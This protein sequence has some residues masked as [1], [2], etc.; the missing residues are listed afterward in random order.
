M[1]CAFRA[2]C[3]VRVFMLACFEYSLASAAQSRGGVR[4]GSLEQQHDAFSYDCRWP[5]ATE[6]G[7]VTHQL[8]CTLR[9]SMGQDGEQ[10]QRGI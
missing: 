7:V 1:L 2:P 5:C 10:R 9:Q 6:G 3:L 8:T 4:R